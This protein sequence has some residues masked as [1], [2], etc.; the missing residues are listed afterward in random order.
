MEPPVI[1]P[2]PNNELV[3]QSA[4]PTYPYISNANIIQYAPNDTGSWSGS[5][6]ITIQEALDRIVAKTPG[7]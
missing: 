1:I 6:P 3:T 2:G 7:A 5:A 4:V